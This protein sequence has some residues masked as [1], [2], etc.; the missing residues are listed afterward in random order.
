MHFSHELTDENTAVT[1]LF[2]ANSLPHCRIEFT[3]R[4]ETPK[5][6]ALST[7]QLPRYRV[8][9]LIAQLQEWM[10]ATKDWDIRNANKT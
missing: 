4:I 7:F 6:K 8:A 10:E 5:A 3:I 1:Q 9:A 2:A